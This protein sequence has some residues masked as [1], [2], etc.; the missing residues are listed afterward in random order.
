[1]R[2]RPHAHTF[3][4]RIVEVPPV[5][6][7]THTWLH[8][9]TGYVRA[10][11]PSA[12][13]HRACALSVHHVRAYVHAT[14]TGVRADHPLAP[15]SVHARTQLA[16]AHATP[17]PQRHRAC[18]LRARVRAYV[19][20]HATIACVRTV[21]LPPAPRDAYARSRY[22]HAQGPRPRKHARAPPRRPSL[23][24]HRAC[25][26]KHARARVYV[27]V[28]RVCARSCRPFAPTHRVGA[29]CTHVRAHRAV[30]RSVCARP[31]T[32]RP[33]AP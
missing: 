13:T 12:P 14:V 29:R 5:C 17:S 23:P 26:H 22:A 27:H 7:C 31:P 4:P 3:S 25:A 21:L 33:R 19:L 8:A 9:R 20:A 32:P 16:R 18:A 11:R 2:A 10:H 30:A 28:R 15:G 1:M 24:A 6:T